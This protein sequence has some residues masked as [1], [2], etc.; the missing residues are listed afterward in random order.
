MTRMQW[1]QSKEP[2]PELPE[3][4]RQNQTRPQCIK[5]IELLKWLYPRSNHI[6]EIIEAAHRVMIAHEQLYVPIQYKIP[7]ENEK[8]K[9]KTT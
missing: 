4:F 5:I 9:K 1:Q 8:E 7:L 2:M 3:T 6:R